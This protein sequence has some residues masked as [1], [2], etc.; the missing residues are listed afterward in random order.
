M[1]TVRLWNR[2]YNTGVNIEIRVGNDSVA[3]NNPEYWK[4][5]VAF[6]QA[7]SVDCENTT[8]FHR[9]DLDP[10]HPTN[11]PSYGGWYNDEIFEDD[12]DDTI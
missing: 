1:A 6:Q 3:E 12:V 2:G 4:G 7:A 11:P 9:R 5:N 10:G 8:V